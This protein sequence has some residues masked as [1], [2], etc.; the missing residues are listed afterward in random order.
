MS[1]SDYQRIVEYIM[2]SAAQPM[3]ATDTGIE[4]A[5]K[6]GELPLRTTACSRARYCPDVPPK[7]IV[8]PVDFPRPRSTYS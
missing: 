1:E 6:V 8:R 3:I 4:A 5:Q 7:K 2:Q